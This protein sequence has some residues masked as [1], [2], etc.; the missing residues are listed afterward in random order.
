[1]CSRAKGGGGVVG[2]VARRLV[3]QQS[4]AAHTTQWT[5]FAARLFDNT[6]GE[7]ARR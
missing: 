6:Q 2:L 5:Q 3:A 7:E 1:M 4:R